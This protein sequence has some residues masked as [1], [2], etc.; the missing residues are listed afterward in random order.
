M[1]ISISVLFVFGR[2]PTTSDIQLDPKNIRNPTI[3]DAQLDLKKVGNQT[4]SD[5]ILV[6]TIYNPI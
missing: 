1:E 2:N 6:G 3:S 4:T 5:M